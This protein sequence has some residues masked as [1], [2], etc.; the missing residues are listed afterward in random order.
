MDAESGADSH[1]DI[2]FGLQ[3]LE[4]SCLVSLLFRAAFNHPYTFFFIH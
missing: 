3:L 1:L 2:T 4:S